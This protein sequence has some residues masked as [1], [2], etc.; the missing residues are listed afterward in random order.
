[1]SKT[2]TV[3]PIDHPSRYARASEACRHFRISRSTLWLWVKTRTDFPAPIKAGPK[4]TL[5]DLDA[6]DM[7]LRAS[8]SGDAR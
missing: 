2:S 5:F 7:Y 3:R 6:I 4:V 8:V 1:M